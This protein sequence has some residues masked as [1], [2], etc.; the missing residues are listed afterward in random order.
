VVKNGATT[1]G[2]GLAIS[3]SRAILYASAN[4]DFAIAA[5]LAARQL[6]DQINLYR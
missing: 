1:D 3:S 2:T 4:E 6:R 5:G